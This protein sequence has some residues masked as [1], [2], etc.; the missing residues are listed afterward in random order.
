MVF[1]AIIVATI[2]LVVMVPVFAVIAL[3]VICWG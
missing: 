3:P 1:M 2:F